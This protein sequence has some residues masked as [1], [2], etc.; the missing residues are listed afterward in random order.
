MLPE[1]IHEFLDEI[2]LV[3]CG[4]V[5]SVLD[6]ELLVD[7]FR[8]GLDSGGHGLGSKIT[9]K[10]VLIEGC[11]GYVMPETEGIALVGFLENLSVL[12]V[13]ADRDLRVISEFPQFAR[14]FVFYPEQFEKLISPRDDLFKHGGGDFLGVGA[15]LHDFFPIV[16]GESRELSRDPPC[17]VKRGFDEA[18]RIF[19]V[20]HDCLVLD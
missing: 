20:E 19:V 9:G 17:I 15:A 7:L 18:G 4:D 12:H 13:F 5:A 11:F 3:L 16:T 14:K 6:I 10:L 8:E 1:V 2:T